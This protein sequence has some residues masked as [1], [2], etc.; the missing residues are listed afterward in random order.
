ML[1]EKPSKFEDRDEF[2]QRLQCNI[3]AVHQSILLII[4]D[5]ASSES[6]MVPARQVGRLQEP[7]SDHPMTS[8]P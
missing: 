2:P 1:R 6:D 7:D 4:I 5:S 3:E 8:C